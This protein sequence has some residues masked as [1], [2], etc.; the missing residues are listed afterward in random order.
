MSSIRVAKVQLILDIGSDEPNY[1]QQLLQVRTQ[2][3]EWI[4]KTDD[5]GQYPEDEPNLRHTYKIWGDA[6]CINPDYER[7]RPQK[8]R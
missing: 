5:K 7:F 1:Q 4:K 3:N 6:T 2:L 8:K